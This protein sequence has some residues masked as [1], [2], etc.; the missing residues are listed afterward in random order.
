MNDDM[1]VDHTETVFLSE[2]KSAHKMGTAKIEILKD[3]IDDDDDAV[4]ERNNVP[5]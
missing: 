1:S 3:G 2:G 5:L 4:D